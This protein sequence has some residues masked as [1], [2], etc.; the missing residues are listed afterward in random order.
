MDQIDLLATKTGVKVE[1]A[2]GDVYSM[3]TTSFAWGVDS[4][5][6]LA[7]SYSMVLAVNSDRRGVWKQEDV[8]PVKPLALLASTYSWLGYAMIIFGMVF[9]SA[10]ARHQQDQVDARTMQLIDA[11]L[12]KVCV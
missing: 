5:T 10:R 11:R 1:R 7:D 12:N 8:D 4:N 3:Q 2:K 6:T 9:A